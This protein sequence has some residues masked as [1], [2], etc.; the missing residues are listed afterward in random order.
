MMDPIYHRIYSKRPDLP[1]TRS[2]QSLFV[3]RISLN[4]G[5]AN[6]AGH[7]GHEERRDHKEPR[8]HLEFSSEWLDERG[9]LQS[10]SILCD[11]CDLCGHS[12][13]VAP[14]FV[15]SAHRP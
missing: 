9:S 12:F 8:G 4:S 11:L 6:S 7:H 15:A 3:H 1:K 13:S 14:L 5:A 10:S 2:I